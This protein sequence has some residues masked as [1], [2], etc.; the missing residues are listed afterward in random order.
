MAQNNNF[1]HASPTQGDFSTRVRAAGIQ[2]SAAGESIAEYPGVD[3]AEVGFMNSPG[4][5]A[6]ILGDYTCV[7]IGIVNKGGMYYITQWFAE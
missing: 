6:N 4:H 7:G 2:Y 1:S 5:R 3:Q